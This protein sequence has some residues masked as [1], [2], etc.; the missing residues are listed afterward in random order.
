MFRS[1]ACVLCR[2]LDPL[3]EADQPQ[4]RA[5][6]TPHPAVP[7]FHRHDRKILAPQPPAPAVPPPRPAAPPPSE[8]AQS[9]ASSATAPAPLI[10]AQP[11]VERAA[12]ALLCAGSFLDGRAR[13][14]RGPLSLS[15]ASRSP[16]WA[17]AAPL[18][19]RCVRRGWG[20]ASVVLGTAGGGRDR[21]GTGGGPWREEKLRG[22]PAL[23][24]E[25]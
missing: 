10:A 15:A 20:A 1:E 17:R 14:T 13:G 6:L 21:S 25:E 23:P 19:R 18:L 11:G 22:R 3:K 24:A 12:A 7:A 5:P 4:P 16:L 8:H 2:G 9:P